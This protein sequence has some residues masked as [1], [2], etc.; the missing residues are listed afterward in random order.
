MT[1]HENRSC[2]LL[3]PLGGFMISTI[4][5]AALAA[6]FA[7]MSATAAHAED[8]TGWRV[9][10]H[11]GY[12]ALSSVYTVGGV[13]LGSGVGYDVAIGKSVIF[14]VEANIGYSSAK[15]EGVLFGVSYSTV[16][17]RDLELSARIG[18]KLGENTLAYLKA[19]YSNAAYE[20]VAVGRGFAGFESGTVDGVRAGVGIEQA[21]GGRWYAKSEY[22][23]TR[24][25]SED[26]NR[27][28]FLVGFGYRF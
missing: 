23:F 15:D 16:A 26:A 20:T 8:F 24:Y 9:D 11:G 22:R 19:G 17:R 10:V 2:R 12:D 13:M 4:R 28:Q 25:N 7:L 3:V 6:S 5:T 14:G 27:N 21:L 1:G 18:A